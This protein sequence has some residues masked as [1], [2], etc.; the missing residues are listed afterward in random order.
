VPKP[1]KAPPA[2]YAGCPGVRLLTGAAA[3]HRQHQLSCQL[4]SRLPLAASSAGTLP[5]S[6]RVAKAAC[7]AGHWRWV[8][9]LDACAEVVFRGGPRR[10]PR[11]IRAGAQAMA[12]TSAGRA[13]AGASSSTGNAAQCSTAAHARG[14][15]SQQGGSPLQLRQRRITLTW[16][17]QRRSRGP[18]ASAAPPAAPQPPQRRLIAAADSAAQAKAA[19]AGVSAGGAAAAQPKR[20]SVGGSVGGSVPALPQMGPAAVH[21]TDQ[22][23]CSGWE[24]SSSS[25]DRSGQSSV[26]TTARMS[27]VWRAFEGALALAQR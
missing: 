17:G 16:P 22:M 23:P 11:L 4:L 20:G 5:R 18:R 24:T 3:A 15:G 21:C 27:W 10:R 2:R 26:V 8:L 7:K 13:L 6:L 9:R 25:G 12:P 14:S 19:P 1:S